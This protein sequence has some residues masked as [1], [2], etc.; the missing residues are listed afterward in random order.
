MDAWMHGWIDGSRERDEL[1]KLLYGVS[2]HSFVPCIL[3]KKYKLLK[4][5]S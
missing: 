4:P 3:L 5:F 1:V 2:F